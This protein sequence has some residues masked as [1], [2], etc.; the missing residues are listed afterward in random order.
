MRALCLIA[1]AGLGL[2][3]AGCGSGTVR[4]DPVTPVSKYKE[5]IVGKWEAD[6]KEQL[7]QGYEFAP[8]GGLKVT[9]QGMAEAVP[10]K[11]SWVGDRALELEYQASA[12]AQKDYAAAV[13]AYK[14][15]L[16]KTVEGGGPIGDAVGKSLDMISD[17]LPAKEKAKVILSEKP[18]EMLIVTLER[19]STLN[20]NR[21]K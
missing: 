19:G 16:R 3:V 4:T 9:F 12:G 17:E 21:A 18:R 20:F 2:L 6:T 1:A 14:E 13:K 7:V 10:G 5:M 11:Y 15:P 8:D